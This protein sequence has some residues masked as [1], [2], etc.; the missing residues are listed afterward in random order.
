MDQGLNQDMEV[1]GPGPE[2]A[3]LFIDLLIGNVPIVRF[4]SPGAEAQFV[5]DVT[6]RLEA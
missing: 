3:V 1:R 4:C 2:N 5:K 6:R